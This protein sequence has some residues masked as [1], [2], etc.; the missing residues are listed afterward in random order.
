MI[1][2]LTIHL[3][4]KLLSDLPG[5]IAHQEVAPYRKVKHSPETI[6]NAKIS[7]V[8]ILFYLKNNEMH[9]VLMQRPIYKGKHSGQISFPGGKKEKND[10]NV[11][12]TALRELE[13][14]VGVQQQDVNVI[15]KLS[16][17]FIPVSNFNVSPVLGTL[18]YTPIFYP[19]K[20]E[21]QEIIEVKIADLINDKNLKSNKIKLENNTLLKTPTFVFGQKIVWGATALMLN[22]LK[23]LLLDWENSPC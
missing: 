9:T 12:S 11:F 6:L 18:N 2:A 22:E 23:H 17:V 16:D 13:E 10:F 15:G 20:R 7:S 19:D 3:K 5:A 14:E 4:Q 21:V 8:L 1:N